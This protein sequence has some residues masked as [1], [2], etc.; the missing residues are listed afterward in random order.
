[1]KMVVQPLLSLSVAKAIN[2]PN[3]ID[4]TRSQVAIEEY[5]KGSGFSRVDSI[6]PGQLAMRGNIVTDGVIF[7]T[8]I[9]IPPFIPPTY[10]S[11][12]LVDTNYVFNEP[13]I[14]RPRKFENTKICRV[15]LRKENQKTYNSNPADLF[16]ALYKRFE[17]L[18]NA[19]ANSEFNSR[20]ELF[21]EFDSYWANDL[22]IHWYMKAE[23]CDKSML[24]YIILS[25]DKERIRI[26]S[27]DAESVEHFANASGFTHILQKVPYID[28]TD[29]LTLP[30]PYTYGDFLKLVKDTGHYTFLKSL[31]KK[32]T[33]SLLLFGFNLPDGAKHYA[34]IFLPPLSPYQ[35]AKQMIYPHRMNY[36]FVKQYLKIIGGHVKSID[37]GWLMKRGGSETV[38]KTYSKNKKIAIVGCGS[39]GSALAYK[40]SKSGISD[41]VLIDPSNL[42]SSNIG[43]HILGM[44]DIHMNKADSMAKYLQKQ[45]IGCTVQ[46]ISDK[47]ESEEGLATLVDVDLIIT[48]IGS[49]APAVEPWLATLATKGKIPEMVACWL[50]AD[51]IAGHVIR[52]KQGTDICFEDAVDAVSVL[53]YDYAATLIQGEVGCNSEYM[54]YAY[55]DADYHINRMAKFIL[56]IINDHEHDGITSIGEIKK[57]ALHLKR[58]VIEWSIEEIAYETLDL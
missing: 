2:M 15:C 4:L 13:H 28:L 6:I 37:R 49:D 27:D 46:A 47:V 21:S 36:F 14:E 53:N 18:C 39:I 58:K 24:N 9:S 17:T 30:L 23:P 20:E 52:I 12:H 51:A 44:S 45:F 1:M 26:V 41:M 57:H 55:I 7:D 10:P 31:T 25:E 43:R 40:L 42:E 38:M 35:K 48:A 3:D 50:E 56:N 22:T 11:F 19:L 33:G 5:L 32:A 29:K 8:V 16:H 34:T 54:P